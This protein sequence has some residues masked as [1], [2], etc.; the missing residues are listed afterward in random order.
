MHSLSLKFLARGP[1]Q[2][3]VY[4]HLS[5][6]THCVDDCPREPFGRNCDRYRSLFF[7][8]GT[9]S[10]TSRPG[11]LEAGHLLQAFWIPGSFHRNFRRG[12]IDV[13]QVCGRQLDCQRS[14]VL[15]QAV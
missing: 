13:A 15:F 9:T 3:L 4:V 6:L 14:D 10:L 11:Q 1:E 8:F 12:G 7:M 2:N 5:R